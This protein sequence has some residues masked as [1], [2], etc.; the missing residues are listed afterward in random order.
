[1]LDAWW[2]QPEAV[3]N[4]LKAFQ[5]SLFSPL[6]DKLGFEPSPNDS[7]DVVLWRVTAVTHAAEADDSKT[8]SEIKRRFSPFMTSNDASQIPGDLQKNIFIH[9][10]RT[11][12]TTEWEKALDIYKHPQNPAEKLAAIQAMCRAQEPALIKRTLDMI[13]IDE[14]KPQDYLSFFYS[15]AMNPLSRRQIWAFLQE[16]LD[17]LTLKLEGSFSLG[18]IVQV[19]F[20][21]LTSLDDVSAVEEFFKGRD[22]SK[23]AQ[24]IEQGLD[25]VRSKAAWLE[26]SREEVREWLEANGYM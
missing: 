13:L 6:V 1:V 21:S 19:S 4:G 5:R 24:L 23:Y 20:D 15:S 14:V 7:P 11:G 17:T 3:R 12:G 22:T 9:A 26:R 8:I 25:A 16:N 10:V 18:N 2:D